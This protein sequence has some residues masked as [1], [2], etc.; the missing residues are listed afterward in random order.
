MFDARALILGVLLSLAAVGAQAT[1][2]TNDANDRNGFVGAVYAMTNDV[3]RNEIVAY[4]RRSD[5][6][7]ERI[8]AFA[9]GGRGGVFDAGEGLDPLISAYSL[10]LTQ[11]R[12]HLLAVNA[13]SN[14]VTVFRVQDD[15]SLRRTD[16]RRVAGVGPNSIAY[17]DGRVYVSSIDADGRFEGEPDQ[18]GILTGF[19]LSPGGRLFRIPWSFRRL[20][21]RPGAVQFSPDGR[22]LV[23]SSINA[24]SSA[25]RS[26]NQDEI[27]VFR[28]FSSGRLSRSPV[29][30]ATSTLRDNAEGRN[31][32]TAIGFEVVEDEGEA[33]VVATEA[34]EFRPDG[35][36]PAFA[37]LQTGSVSTWR[38]ADDGKLE[39]IEVDVLTGPSTTD[40]AR[41][42]CW[43]EFSRDENTFWVANALDAT[44]SSF[45]F[46]EG[47]VSLIDATAAAGNP[48]DNSSAET[49]F[50]TSDG[51]IDL[52]ASDDG[53]YL[54][55]LLGLAGTVVVYEV[56]REGAGRGL[57]EIQRV[58][59][60][61]E[62]NTQGI[63]A[64]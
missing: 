43:I 2:G 26:D 23:V 9:T 5:G 1:Y 17:F 13:G 47:R 22:F 63:V 36:P 16:R 12:R 8:G 38:L 14:T 21:S 46:E 44:I 37:S 27:S 56:D 28:V 58:Q 19:F 45:S 62:A 35:S 20:P 52:W 7:L 60:L 54:Y 48:P 41:T 30:A 64:F 50:D 6:T 61:P 59:D 32:P 4:G 24:G 42:A 31:L 49:A 18:Q 15:F 25:L 55:Q 10:V 39:A 29:G 34:R 51:F 3:R 40:G 57:T 53:R 33:Y 11:N